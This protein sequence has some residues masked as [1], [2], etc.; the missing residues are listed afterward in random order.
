MHSRLTSSRPLSWACGQWLANALL[1]AGRPSLMI[2]AIRVGR[3]SWVEPR[4]LLTTTLKS[5]RTTL[6]FTSR[7]FLLQRWFLRTSASQHCDWDW[8]GRCC[9]TS[10]GQMRTN[11]APE[12][13][14]SSNLSPTMRRSF[15][16]R[17]SS[18]DLFDLRWII[19]CL[20]G[21][22]SLYNWFVLRKEFSG[23]SVGSK[24]GNPIEKKLFSN[25]R[26]EILLLDWPNWSL[27]GGGEEILTA[28]VVRSP[29]TFHIVLIVE[30]L[31]VQYLHS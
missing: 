6:T 9:C 3:P 28:L 27:N 2:R 16:N 14:R 11:W 17:H 23:G 25:P 30:Q 15:R 31:L 24:R 13:K 21:S 8:V 18:S 10:R 4:R 12:E 29:P 20:S 26:M 7:I 1:L 19:G 5:P 22:V